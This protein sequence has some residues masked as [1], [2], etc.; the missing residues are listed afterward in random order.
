MYKVF[1]KPLSLISLCKI[2]VNILKATIRCI[3]ACTKHHYVKKYL[4][5][6]CTYIG[7]T[8]RVLSSIEMN[9]ILDLRCLFHI[10]TSWGTVFLHTD[11]VEQ[12]GSLQRLSKR[13]QGTSKTEVVQTKYLFPSS[14]ISK[15]SI[16]Y[17]FQVVI[18][19]KTISP[20]LSD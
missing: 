20:L 13:K 7:N 9:W 19:N 12:K 3:Q 16:I 6:Y 8:G 10:Y 1:Q 4:V 2:V 14:L 15:K 5:K 11:S 18:S 17:V